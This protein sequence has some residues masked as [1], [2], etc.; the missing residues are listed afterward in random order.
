MSESKGFYAYEKFSSADMLDN[1]GL[2]PY[3]D[4]WSSIEQCNVRIFVWGGK[5]ILK[6]IFEPRGGEKNFF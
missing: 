6:K 2:P 3:A 1:T 4:F 5:S